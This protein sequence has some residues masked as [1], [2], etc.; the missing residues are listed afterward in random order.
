MAEVDW[1]LSSKRMTVLVRVRGQTIVDGPPIVRRF[2]GQPVRNLM[3]WMAKQGGFWC[4][5]LDD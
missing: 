1:V 3:G 4:R 5:T 2:K